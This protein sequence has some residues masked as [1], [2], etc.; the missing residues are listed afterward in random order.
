MM[1]TS[2]FVTWRLAWI[3]LFAVCTVTLPFAALVDNRILFTISATATCV[4]GAAFTAGESVRRSQLR[5]GGPVVMGFAISAAAI[6]LL[7][8][9][10]A[11]ST[12]PL[13]L[14]AA[15]IYIA[16]IH[17]NLWGLSKNRLRESSED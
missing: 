1:L 12:L 9:S 7:R 6:P 3:A 13:A 16:A 15:C 8:W 17:T 5:V 14:A 4:V 10:S 11:W 2:I